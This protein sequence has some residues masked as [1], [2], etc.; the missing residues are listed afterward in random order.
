MC[1]TTV[2]FFLH[3]MEHMLGVKNS[4]KSG[5]SKIQIDIQYPGQIKE[6]FYF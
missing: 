5:N 3:F 6:K 4:K 1:S 2:C